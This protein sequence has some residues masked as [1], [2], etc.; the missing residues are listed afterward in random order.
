[1]RELYDDN[2][3]ITHNCTAPTPAACRRIPSCVSLVQ[4][5]NTT[6]SVDYGRITTTNSAEHTTPLQHT[7]STHTEKPYAIEVNNLSFSY[8]GMKCILQNISF[9]LPQNT[10]LALLGENGG[11]KSTLLQCLVGLL[12]PQCGSIS[13]LG[14]PYTKAKSSI[15]YLPQ[16]PPIAFTSVVTAWEMIFYGARSSALFG[17]RSSA[18]KEKAEY[19]LNFISLYHKK[20]TKFSHLSGGEKQRV[21]FARSLMNDP[22]I[23]ILDEPTASIDAQS[24]S[25][26]YELLNSY[27]NGLSLIMATHDIHASR[28]FFDSI[29]ILHNKTLSIHPHDSAMQVLLS[30]IYGE[31]TA[32]RHP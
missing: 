1:M 6:D 28:S 32:C 12:T 25:C 19:L 11:G 3:C 30:Y 16:C 7:V 23:L 27:D 8:A 10:K 22:S 4:Q 13:F 15:G 9:S 20:N 24:R 29:A 17:I 26:L 21:L 5:N 14:L 31:H 18:L 2:T